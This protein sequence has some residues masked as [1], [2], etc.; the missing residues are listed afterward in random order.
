MGFFPPQI[1]ISKS[2]LGSWSPESSGFTGTFYWSYMYVSTSF[3][4]QL[5]LRHIGQTG[6]EHQMSAIAYRFRSGVLLP[7]SNTLKCF[8]L[9]HS[10]GDLTIY[11]VYLSCW[12]ISHKRLKSVEASNGFASGD[13]LYLSPSFNSPI[14]TRRVSGDFWEGAKVLSSVVCQYKIEFA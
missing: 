5:K 7:H 3:A 2:G 9:Y 8:D 12:K 6:A 11:L 1:N 4:R 10:S 13:T 14:S